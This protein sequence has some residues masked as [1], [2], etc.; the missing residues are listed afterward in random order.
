MTL[1][2]VTAVARRCASPPVFGS[3][4]GRLCG[5]DDIADPFGYS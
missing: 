4:S 3:R 1:R 2:T 5:V